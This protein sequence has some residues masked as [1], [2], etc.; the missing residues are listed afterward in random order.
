MLLHIQKQW[1]YVI[2]YFAF[3]LYNQH[4]CF[5]DEIKILFLLGVFNVVCA[6]YMF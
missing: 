2:A 1:N 3:K 5:G 4:V 6:A